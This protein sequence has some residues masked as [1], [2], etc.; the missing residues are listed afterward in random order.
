VCVCMRVRVRVR[1]AN[2]WCEGTVHWHC[3]LHQTQDTMLLPHIKCSKQLSVTLL[4]REHGRLNG[5][6]NLN[7]A[8]FGWRLIVLR[9]S[10]HRMHRQKH[11]K[12]IDL[13]RKT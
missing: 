13:S 12:F 1:F 7:M 6:V 10:L 9:S 8:N 4:W 3:I 5:F 2:G 11:G